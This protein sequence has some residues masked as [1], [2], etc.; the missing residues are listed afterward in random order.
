MDVTAAV[1]MDRSAWG[2]VFRMSTRS[3]PYRLS[4]HDRWR[5]P[6]TAKVKVRSFHLVDEVPLDP[7]EAEQLRRDRVALSRGWYDVPD[8]PDRQRFWDGHQFVA[9]RPTPQEPA[10]VTPEQATPASPR[11]QPMMLVSL[12]ALVAGLVLAMFVAAGLLAIWWAAAAA[13]MV[14]GAFSVLGFSADRL[15]T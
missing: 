13:A 12:V 5:D 9:S 10:R 4:S 2:Y 6:S 15:T 7:E 8:R 14:A 11:R 3:T 1:G